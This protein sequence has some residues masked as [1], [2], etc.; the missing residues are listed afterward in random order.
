MKFKISFLTFGV[1]LA[2]VSFSILMHD[3]NALTIGG[4]QNKSNTNQLK[5]SGYWVL[6]G[7]SI[8]GSA[9]GVGAHNWTW[10]ENQP[11]CSG[12][13]TFHDPYV[14]ENV[15]IDGAWTGSCIDISNSIV[16][17]EIYNC[18][19]YNSGYGGPPNNDAGIWFYNVTKGTLI[20]NYCHDNAYAGIHIIY[21]DNNTI[22]DN[23]LNDN[24]DPGLKL[25][26]SHNNIVSG[27]NATYNDFGI[28]LD[29]SN[30]NDVYDNHVE[31]IAWYGIYLGTSHDN[32]VFR[33]T[34][35]NCNASG[36]GTTL[37]NN[38]G[39]HNNTC[40]ENLADGINLYSSHCT[41]IID[42]TFTDNSGSGINLFSSNGSTI[43]DNNIIWNGLEGIIL[44]SSNDSIVV[45]NDLLNNMGCI[46]EINCENNIFENNTCVIADTV[47]PVLTLYAPYDTELF[48]NVAPTYNITIVE[49]NFNASWYV[50]DD[51]ISSLTHPF[52]SPTGM[53]DQTLWDAMQD[54]TISLSFNANDTSGKIG[55][56]SVNVSK[57][58]TAP[59][60]TII[61]PAENDEFGT[62]APTFSITIVEVNFNTSWYTMD[63]GI[64][65]IPFSGI[66]GTFDQDTWDSMADGNYTLTFYANDFTG[67]VGS[68]NVKIIKDTTPPDD[69]N[70]GTPPIGGYEISLL[71]CIFG[72]ASFILAKK[73]FK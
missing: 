23:V 40:E 43:S 2:L 60:I 4:N 14:I 18:T 73:K 3:N 54:G 16:Y 45:N 44:D 8:N 41:D 37:S 38:N 62:T 11:W 13:G 70:G 25:R 64:T 67:N 56:V 1:I 47:D 42:N 34:A 26:Q 48:G 55:T 51:G 53:I 20:E 63:G 68:E 22:I 21:S 71:I 49:D 46:T 31:N 69:G 52:S 27:N 24:F 59:V 9:S 12:S 35:R 50:L 36:L 57:D 61:S 33:N 6:S 28:T 17:F 32:T 39:F 5:N 15:T 58:T 10:A 65:I 7:I 19:L 29:H 30:Y 72:I 66:T